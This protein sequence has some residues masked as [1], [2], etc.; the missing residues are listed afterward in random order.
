MKFVLQ[1]P[2]RRV[3]LTTL[4]ADK[5]QA[6]RQLVVF[7]LNTELYGV[8]INVVREIIRMQKLTNIPQTP[9]YVKGVINLRGS[10]TPVIDLRKRLD[11]QVRDATTD[12]R[13]VVV[14]VG[15]Q[16][17]G[18]IVDQ[19][20]EVLRISS[21]AIEPTSAIVT[22]TDSDYILGIAKLEDR[23]IILLD[24][25]S[26]LCQEALENGRQANREQQRLET[27]NPVEAILEQTVAEEEADEDREPLED[28]DTLSV[29]YVRLLEAFPELKPFFAEMDVTEAGRDLM[30]FLHPILDNLARPEALN[31]ALQA[32]VEYHV[33]LGIRPEHH[34]LIGDTL[35]QM[36]AEY[37]DIG[38]T[39]EFEATWIEQYNAVIGALSA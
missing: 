6:E 16:N 34:P 21:D 18:I 20:T 5:S 31:E 2:G 10:V 22:A 28:R 37:L 17:I 29:F 23:L 9:S 19:V 26:A 35:R 33:D 1:Q 38:W 30:E 3:V 12:T 14:D 4:S 15:N 8:D 25:E 24:L 32:L 13:I 39:E 7:S 36:V 27:E 11:L